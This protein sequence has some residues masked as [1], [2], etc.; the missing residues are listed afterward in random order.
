[1]AKTIIDSNRC[2]GCGLCIE[3]CPKKILELSKSKLNDKGYHP[4][5]CVDNEKCTGCA[6]CAAMCPDCA[7]I[8]ER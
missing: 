3:F 1:M 6:A 5:E 4:C 8:V 2:K 7:I